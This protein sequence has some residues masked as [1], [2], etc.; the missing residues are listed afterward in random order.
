MRA[1]GH[2]LFFI[3]LSPFLYSQPSPKNITFRS[4]L[5][6]PGKSLADIWGYADSAGNEYALVGVYDNISI[7]NVTDPQ[8]PVEKVSVPAPGSVWHEVR[9][10]GKYAFAVSEGGGGLQII[11]LS[12]LP[13]SVQYINWT[14][15]SSI[16][17]Q[18]L[19]AHALHISGHYLYL[20]GSNIGN[21]NTLFIDITDPWNPAYAG[22]YAYP[23]GGVS[24]Y[25][26]DGYVRNDTLWECHISSG[27]FAA[28]DV[29]DK[30][31]PLLISTQGTPGFATHN[32]WL[33]DDGKTLFVT[34]EI[35]NSALLSYD[36][37]N[38]P[39]IPLLDKIQLTPGSGSVVHNTHVINDY[40]V[41]SWYKDGLAIVDGHRPGNL[42]VVGCYDTYPQGSGDGYNG[43]W[44]VYPYLPSGTILASDIDNGL[45]V[46]TPDYRRA[47][48][49]EGVVTDSLCGSPLYNVKVELQGS[50]VSCFSD[51]SG[52]YR[53]G[54]PDSGSYTVVVS[55][56]GYVTRTVTGVTLSPGLITNL[57]VKL[58]SSSTVTVDID[59]LD[60]VT[61]TPVQNASVLIANDSVSF[62]INSDSSG[63][64][65]KCDLL[66]GIY[67]VTAGKWGY[68]T[69]CMN[70]QSFTSPS[71]SL[72]L[73][74]GKE[75]YDDFTF[76]YGWAV[77]G[78]SP[79]KWMPGIPVGTID[80]FSVANPDSDVAGDCNNKCY[81]TD[82][83]GGGAWDH[84]VDFGNTVLSSP[85]FDATVFTQPLV[86]YSRWFYN[87]GF[88]YG[89]P[90]DTFKVSVSNGIDTA[91]LELVKGI[92]TSNG[93]WVSRVFKISDFLPLTSSMR[94]IAETGDY[95][96]VYNVVE[97]ALDSFAV[98]ESPLAIEDYKKNR[99]V[100]FF[101]ERGKIYYDLMDASA[102]GS[103][104]VIDILGRTIRE[105]PLA[106]SSGWISPGDLVPGTYIFRLHY[107]KD[108]FAV[109]A[110]VTS[111][112]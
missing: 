25:V 79:N 21:G 34:D 73:Q 4:N 66:S 46:L 56:P 71:N 32:D 26:H 77:S 111:V 80:S 74:T 59:V 102:A 110:L 100:T 49:L 107:G 78:L 91:E 40:C 92:D 50:A 20:Y 82:N 67:N 88:L 105:L 9:T 60:A 108:Q 35:T 104:A 43:C 97:A 33:S 95:G 93:H 85:L 39:N 30:S 70:G 42:V 16:A 68:A 45:F 48:Y 3:L 14:G 37:S 76:N 8:N 51:L 62:F 36:V 44:G 86:S 72:V 65:H 57:N 11:N 18:L 75:F 22:T 109:K 101:Y 55:A 27:F 10:S 58:F 1:C 28:V 5:S 84:D 83:L 99:E 69:V 54:T 6:Y 89:Y 13:D 98:Y 106:K 7:V 53:T 52:E 63:H 31:N 12:W 90:D 94:L 96:P 2:L 61:S 47:C 81:V 17:G 38:L 15:D 24:S 23:S 41:T 103:L 64:I 112:W 87:K 19:T 29:T